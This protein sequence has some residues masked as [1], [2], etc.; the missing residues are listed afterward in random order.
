MPTTPFPTV[1]DE[2]NDRLTPAMR[3]SLC[4]HRNSQPITPGVIR[5][6][7][8]FSNDAVY[9]SSRLDFAVSNSFGPKNGRFSPMKGRFVRAYTVSLGV[10]P[11]PRKVAR[12]APSRKCAGCRSSKTRRVLR[13][14]SLLSPAQTLTP[15]DTR[16]PFV[17]C[18]CNP[19]RLWRSKPSLQALH[20]PRFQA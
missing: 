5:S 3:R 17:S 18:I 14:P 6:K 12:E 1:S 2:K 11:P 8:P 20:S 13:Y 9:V 7:P 4:A 19:T 16:T 15:P 10:F